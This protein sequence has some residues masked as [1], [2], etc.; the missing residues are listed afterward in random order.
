MVCTGLQ[1]RGDLR[2]LRVDFNDCVEMGPTPIDRV[3]STFVV[4]LQRGYV[5]PACGQCLLDFEDGGFSGNGVACDAV[6]RARRA[7]G[8]RAQGDLT[9][10]E[11]KNA[12][13]ADESD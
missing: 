3:D 11:N 6:G 13:Q 7:C 12:A 2:G 9:E 1:G 8:V 10:N 4:T 5:K